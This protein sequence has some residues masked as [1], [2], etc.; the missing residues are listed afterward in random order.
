MAD[1]KGKGVKV[2]DSDKIAVGLK[3]IM[4]IAESVVIP[5]EEA[6]SPP[7]AAGESSRTLVDD[8]PL[9]QFLTGSS[10][11]TR[12][13]ITDA[14]AFESADA[15]LAGLN[16][17]PAPQPAE[18]EE[19]VLSYPISP[20]ACLNFS[21]SDGINDATDR[22]IAQLKLLIQLCEGEIIEASLR[23]SV[24]L[25]IQA[26]GYE[27]ARNLFKSLWSQMSYYRAEKEKLTKLLEE[28]YPPPCRGLHN[29]EKIPEVMTRNKKEFMDQT[30]Q[31][32]PQVSSF[33]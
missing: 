6:D 21:S 25:L 12:E 17:N 23:A 10:S 27:Y 31:I 20:P 14:S 11:N 15:L 19:L 24:T 26:A 3:Y 4:Q 18:E 32:P 7:T 29:P 28:A 33:R 5:S 8:V 2:D 30:L 1:N 9:S 22:E 16:L 13:Q